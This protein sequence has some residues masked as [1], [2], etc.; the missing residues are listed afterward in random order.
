MRFV[1]GGGQHLVDLRE[2]AIEVA[3]LRHRLRKTQPG[4]RRVGSRGQCGIESD[5]RLFVIAR[6]EERAAT[7]DSRLGRIEPGLAAVQ[8]RQQRRVLALGELDFGADDRHV[9]RGCMIFDGSAQLLFRAVRVSLA[10]RH[11]GEQQSGPHV[12]RLRA[13][14]VLQFDGG[15][16]LFTPGEKLFGARDSILGA[17]EPVAAR[18]RQRAHARNK[19]GT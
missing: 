10:Q 1:G 7:V 19:Y 3:A 14:H 8:L 11:P 13:E 6:R 2:R 12:V 9:G 4:A 17:D 15:G 16:A 18:E 5:N